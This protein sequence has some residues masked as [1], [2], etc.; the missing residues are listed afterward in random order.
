MPEEVKAPANAPPVFMVHADDDKGV[1]PFRTSV[2]LYSAWKEAGFSAELHIYSA[3]GHGFGMRKKNL[4]VD[5]W[6]DRMREWLGTQ[7]LL[8]TARR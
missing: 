8:T 7:G 4:P 2:R 5:S 6:T 1:P 3:G